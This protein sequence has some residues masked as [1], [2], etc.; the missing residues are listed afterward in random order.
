MHTWITHIIRLAKMVAT[1]SVIPHPSISIEYVTA[2][3]LLR[4]SNGERSLHHDHY[5][6]HAH[7][8][9]KGCLSP[10]LFATY[11]LLC[12]GI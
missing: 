1:I 6:A 7:I 4:F 11:L 10:A 12:K 5:Q 8:R 3:Y 9:P 2:I